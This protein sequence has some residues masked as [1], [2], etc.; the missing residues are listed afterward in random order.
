MND[1]TIPGF[2]NGK[3]LVMHKHVCGWPHSTYMLKRIAALPNPMV[4]RSE[5]REDAIL[6]R[7][8]GFQGISLGWTDK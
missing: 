1:P 8:D 3:T 5:S 7:D 4:C 2:N 6:F